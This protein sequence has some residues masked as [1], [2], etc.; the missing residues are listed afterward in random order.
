MAAPDPAILPGEAQSVKRVVL[1]YRLK[2]TTRLSRLTIDEGNKVTFE[3]NGDSMVVEEW[4]RR[5]GFVKNYVKVAE[6]VPI[7]LEHPIAVAASA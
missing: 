2:D 7:G 5:R 1:Q 6:H 4:L 3:R